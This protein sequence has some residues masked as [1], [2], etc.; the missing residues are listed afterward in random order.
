MT[1]KPKVRVS[2]AAMLSFAARNKQ[3]WT[4]RIAARLKGKVYKVVVRPDVMY[5][6]EMGVTRM[7]SS[8]NETIKLGRFEHVQ[9]GDILEKKC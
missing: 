5:G 7:D 4:R 6:L 9:R 1:F 2:A 3:M 8:R